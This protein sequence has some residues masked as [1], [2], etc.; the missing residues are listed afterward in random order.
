MAASPL[1]RLRKICLSLPEVREVVSWGAPTWRVKTIF[2]MYSGPDSD[3]YADPRAAVWLKT[4]AE[5]QEWLVASDASRFFKPPYVGVKGWTGVFLD[6]E[7]DW[8]EL[9]SLLWDGWRMSVTKTLAAK[10]P[11]PAR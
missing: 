4:S 7:T 6:G 2:A 11:P 8:A 10:H 5:N 3:H 1:T 9:E